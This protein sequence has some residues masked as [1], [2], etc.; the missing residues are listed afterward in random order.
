[1]ISSIDS[2][3]ISVLKRH[4]LK[5]LALLVAVVIGL[6]AFR[7]FLVERG[8]SAFRTVAITAAVGR[9]APVGQFMTSS[10]HTANL[11]SYIG[12]RKT[13]V[14]FVAGGCAGCASSIP[15]VAQHFRQLRDDGVHVVTLGLYGAF[16][17]GK[18][19]SVQLKS[20]GSEAAGA[21]ISRPGWTWGMASKKLTFAYDPSGTP[22]EYF[23]IAPNGNIVYQNSVPVSTLPQ[24]LTAASR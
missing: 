8:S 9:K 16:P 22:D 14:W 3:H 7:I 10:G 4:R 20:F 11:A 2:P 18:Q 5:V 24:L 1:M 21:S 13:L 6:V 17:N 23:L 19:G 12:G 15:A